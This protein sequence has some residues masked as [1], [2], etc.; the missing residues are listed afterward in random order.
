MKKGLQGSF[1]Y[2]HDCVGTRRLPTCMKIVNLLKEESSHS[3][4]KISA[5]AFTGKTGLGQALHCFEDEEFFFMYFPIQSS[6]R[7][8]DDII[9]LMDPLPENQDQQLAKQVLLDSKGELDR[10]ISSLKMDKTPVL[11]FDEFHITYWA[12]QE[13]HPA[14]F[15]LRN[16]GTTMSTK[17]AKVLALAS[18]RYGQNF[19]L[20]PVSLTKP[21]Q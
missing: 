17:Q 12:N 8:P 7:C 18:R 19:F 15:L 9:N 16:Y 5:P 10:K 4:F 1:G 11:I 3:T 13:G 21:G 14:R 6:Q 2:N 20:V